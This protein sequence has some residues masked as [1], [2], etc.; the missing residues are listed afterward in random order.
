MKKHKE[1]KL[2]LGIIGF[3][4]V[5][6]AIAGVLIANHPVSIFDRNQD[7]CLRHPLVGDGS[8]VLATSAAALASSVDLLIFC[9]PTP[10][11]SRMVAV[12]I[13][14]AVQTGLVVLET[15]T[16]SPEDVFELE[17]LLT[18]SGARVIDAAVIGGIHALSQGE[19]VFLVGAA[20]DDTGPVAVVLPQLAAEI[21]HLGSIGGGMRA[22]LVANAVSH[23]VYV[24]LAE[25]V[26]VAAAQEIPMDVLY[27]LLARNSG[28][29][30][31]LTHRIGERLFRG[32]F[33]G[34]MSTANAR[35][36]SRLFLETAHRLGVP[37]FA[38]QAAH[39]VYEIATHEGMAAD[40]Y[41]IIAKLWEK[42]SGVHLSEKGVA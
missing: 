24:V 42:W 25:A 35:K 10:E 27:R 18:P 32:D 13:A 21:F 39:S 11:A 12:E 33:S 2:R 5:G 28:L 19:A 17:T 4:Q 22:K 9:L 15:S 37:V 23:A 1:E 6:Q 14:G 20:P 38:T 16:V 30:R 36:D 29:T 40:D 8:I 41:A 3:G 34:G 31:P 26:A 7:Q